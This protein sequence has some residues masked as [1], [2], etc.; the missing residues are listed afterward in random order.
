MRHRL[1]RSEE[2]LCGGRDEDAHVGILGH[3][4]GSSVRVEAVRMSVVEEAV[5]GC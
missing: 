3:C 5:V 4:D 1:G 2:V